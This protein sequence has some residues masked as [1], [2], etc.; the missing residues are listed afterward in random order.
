MTSKDPWRTGTGAGAQA[1]QRPQ[2]SAKLVCS[3]VSIVC[4]HSR[5]QKAFPRLPVF[6]LFRLTF[7]S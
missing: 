5:L 7:S 3:I 1:Q 6:H 2:P 4:L